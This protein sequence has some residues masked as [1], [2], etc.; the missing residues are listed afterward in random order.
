MVDKGVVKRETSGCEL[1]RSAIGQRPF[2]EPY[3]NDRRIANSTG[4]SCCGFVRSARFQ[5]VSSYLQSEMPFKFCVH[6][7]IIMQISIRSSFENLLR[8][9]VLAVSEVPAGDIPM[10]QI[11]S[12]R[13]IFVSRICASR[14]KYRRHGSNTE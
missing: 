3:R 11:F 14:G 10:P 2:L 5:H 9:R 7:L 13:H 12:V 8:S 4:G 6:V 1:E